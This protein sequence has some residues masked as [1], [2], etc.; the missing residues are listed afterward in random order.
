MFALVAQVLM[1]SLLRVDRT[2]CTTAQ[3]DRMG[4]ILVSGGEITV[5]VPVVEDG[6]VGPN[7]VNT[8]EFAPLPPTPI[9]QALAQSKALPEDKRIVTLEGPA[10]TNAG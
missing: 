10:P 5:N 1:L 9:A 7:N 3:L 6:Q 4:S 2:T 8:V